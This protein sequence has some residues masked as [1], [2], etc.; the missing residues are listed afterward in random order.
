MWIIIQHW[1]YI[2]NGQEGHLI[3]TSTEKGYP[4]SY[5]IGQI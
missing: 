4:I 5:Q 1:F 3:R 2:Y